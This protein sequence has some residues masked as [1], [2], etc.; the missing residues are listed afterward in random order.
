M[1]DALFGSVKRH[2]FN[3]LVFLE[4]LEATSMDP[5]SLSPTTVVSESVGVDLKVRWE[6]HELDPGEAAL[7]LQSIRKE[8][9]IS[10][11]TH[12]CHRCAKRRPSQP[13][14]KGC[15]PVSSKKQI[16]CRYELV[17]YHL[18]SDPDVYYVFERQPHTGH[19]PMTT[20]EDSRWRRPSLIV[21]ERVFE[22]G[23]V[24]TRRCHV[25]LPDRCFV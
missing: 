11:T 25:W 2:Y 24:A 3:F 14:T 4:V 12:H 10:K 13:S 19:D 23:L 20:G 9:I 5:E 22:V 17:T 1:C 21:R 15:K 7:F 8:D 6:D 16:Q 18:K